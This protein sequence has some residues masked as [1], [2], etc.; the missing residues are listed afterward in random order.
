MKVEMVFF[1]FFIFDIT[2]GGNEKGAQ[3]YVKHFWE[4]EKLK[5]FSVLS[6]F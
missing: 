3:H 2:K 6:G 4:S 1:F 5:S